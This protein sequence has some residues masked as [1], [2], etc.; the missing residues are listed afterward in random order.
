MKKLLM[1]SLLILTS[2]FAHSQNIEECR[3]IVDLTIEGVNNGS[4]EK[5]SAFLSADFS[6][7]GQKGAIANMV[8]QQLFAQLGESVIHHD[9]IKQNTIDKGLELVYSIEYKNM[10]VKEAKF[11]FDEKN[12]LQELNLFEM[13]VKTMSKDDTKIEKSSQDVIEIPFTM[14]GKL[15]A[16]KVILNG[17]YKTFILDSGAPKVILNSNHIAGDSMNAKKTLSSSK[18]VNGNISGMDITKVDELDFYGIQLNNQNVLTLDLSHLE[19][20]LETEI[21]GLIGYELLNEYDVLYDYQNQKLTLIDPDYFASYKAENL[22][23]VTVESI[24]LQIEGH[25]PTCLLYTS[26]SPRD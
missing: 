12:L 11:I 1:V 18:D 13:E 20:S 14:A 25:I 19:E 4:S 24:P 3:K 9:E 17:E 6:I 23:A 8:L 16:V 15:I 22:S 7:A 21:Y 10:G 26:P 2:Q 5:L